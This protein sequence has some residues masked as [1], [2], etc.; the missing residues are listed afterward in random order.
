MRPSQGIGEFQE[1]DKHQRPTQQQP[2]RQ[3][4]APACC[5][6]SFAGLM[7]WSWYL[8]SRGC[9]QG[10]L[11]ER[12]HH[13]EILLISTICSPKKGKQ[14]WGGALSPKDNGWSGECGFSRN[15]ELGQK[16]P[17][18]RLRVTEGRHKG[19]RTELRSRPWHSS[20]APLRNCNSGSSSS[21]FPSQVLPH[22]EVL[23]S[24]LSV[25]WPH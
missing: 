12:S 22:Q 13:S 11:S 15:K 1:T 5:L 9:A 6:L 2:S 8:R 16:D 14:Q 25:A 24:E 19:D 21:P 23:W 7:Q 18:R 10:W 3:P 17:G 4:S 20:V